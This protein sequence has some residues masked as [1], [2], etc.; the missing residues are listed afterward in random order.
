ME[1]PR[2][3]LLRIPCL[4]YGIYFLLATFLQ[5]YHVYLVSLPEPIHVAYALCAFSQIFLEVVVFACISAFLWQKQYKI[6]PVLFLA[7][8]SLFLLLRACDLVFVRL[9]DLSVW[10]GMDIFLLQESWSNISELLR[11]TNLPPVVWWLGSLGLSVWVVGWVFLFFLTQKYSL[12][13]SRKMLF[14]AAIVTGILLVLCD[15]CVW[16]EQE[17]QTEHSFSKTLPWKRTVFSS[18]APSIQIEGNL[19]ACLMKAN[20]EK[21]IPS[22]VDKPDLFLFIVESLREDFLTQEVTPHLYAF[23]NTYAAFP[24]AVSAS[25]ATQLS[26]FSLFYSLYPFYWTDREVSAEGSYPLSVLKQMGY[27]IHVYSSSRLEIYSMDRILFGSKYHLLDSYHPFQDKAHRPIYEIDQ[28]NIDTLCFDVVRSPQQGGRVFV[29]FLDGTHFDYS[30][31]PQQKMLFSPFDEINYLK[32]VGKRTNLEN[33]KNRYKNALVHIDQLFGQFLDM[34][35]HTGRLE[36]AN[37][38][39]TADHGEEFDEYGHMFHASYLAPPQLQIPLYM[40][41]GDA[42]S[43]ACLHTERKASQMDIFPTVFHHLLGQ[44]DLFPSLQGRSLL[45]AIDRGYAVGVR[46][47]AVCTPYEFCVESD[48]YRVILGFRMPK[49]VFHCHTLDVHAVED[50]NQESV[51]YTPTFIQTHFSQ[52]LADLFGNYYH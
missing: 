18:H 31:S 8:L 40:K 6:L 12:Y 30:W 49:D 42:K 29:I 47:N 38:I 28:K 39:F 5:I 16:M 24:K 27:T 21:T 43:M 34:M 19:K 48:T 37:I 20:K 44:G 33:V 51:P 4:Y 17:P 50:F 26:W 7:C 45:S 15:I 46:N 32:L 14:G 52:A 25:N 13:C 36:K 9:M 3:P 11:A 41:L 35:E 2:D 23:K 10:H 22:V 1:E